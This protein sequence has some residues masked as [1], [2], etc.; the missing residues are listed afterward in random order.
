MQMIQIVRFCLAGFIN[1]FPEI[2]GSVDKP[3]M[4]AA[5]GREARAKNQDCKIED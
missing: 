2:K 4:P 5:G 3:V 1:R